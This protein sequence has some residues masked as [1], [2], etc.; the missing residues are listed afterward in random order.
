MNSNLS[1]IGR[2][3][4]RLGAICIVLAGLVLGGC[5]GMDKESPP[6]HLNLN[7]DYQPRYWAMGESAF[8]EDRRMMRSPVPG[9]IARGLLREDSD[10]FFGRG[11]DGAYVSS[12]PIPVT[13][14]VLQRGRERYDIFCSMCHGYSGDGRGI[15]MT[16]QYGYTPAPSFHDDRLRQESDGYFYDVVTNGVRSMP[17]YGTQIAVADRWAI[18]AYMRALQRSQDADLQDVPE[19]MR[20]TLQIAEPEAE[21]DAEEEEETASDTEEEAPTTGE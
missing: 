15:I 20:S 11:A 8:F 18:V 9:T 10:F 13:M 12:I 6:I 4:C 14:D 1:L 17:G 16:G 21:L 5:R 19:E 3:A 2:G 7:M